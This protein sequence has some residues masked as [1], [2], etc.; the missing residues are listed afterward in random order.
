[1]ENFGYLFAAYTAIFAAIFLYVVFLWR[2]Q[3]AL[4]AELRALEARLDTLKGAEPESDAG[5]SPAKL[6]SSPL[7]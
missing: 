3:A 4:D 2:R 1:M 6:V 5:E 7:R